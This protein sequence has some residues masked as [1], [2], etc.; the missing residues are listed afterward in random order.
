MERMA[1]DPSIYPHAVPMNEWEL[2]YQ[3]IVPIIYTRPA[4]EDMLVEK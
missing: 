1:I 2:I 4:R 3:Q